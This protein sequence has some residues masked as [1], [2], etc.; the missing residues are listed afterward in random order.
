[1][2]P[3]SIFSNDPSCSLY[4]LSNVACTHTVAMRKNANGA[5]ISEDEGGTGLCE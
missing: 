3:Q 1:L 2:P 5:Q 4:T